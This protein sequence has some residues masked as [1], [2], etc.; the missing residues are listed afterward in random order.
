[1]DVQVYCA[2]LLLGLVALTLPHHYVSANS[3]VS[4][5]GGITA[6]AAPGFTRIEG[7]MVPRWCE[8]SITRLPSSAADVASIIKD[9]RSSC[10]AKGGGKK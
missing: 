5:I 8:A 1:M 4:V 6:P 10:K 2:L 9:L 3:I 7:A